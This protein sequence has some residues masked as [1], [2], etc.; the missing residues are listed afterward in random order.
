LASVISVLPK[1]TSRLPKSYSVSDVGGDKHLKI[2]Q[3]IPEQHTGKAQ[4]QGTTKKKKK[5]K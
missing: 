1:I 2:T 4:H 3:T 5:A